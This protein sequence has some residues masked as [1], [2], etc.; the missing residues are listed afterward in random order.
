MN[1][2]FPLDKNL[3]YIKTDKTMKVLSIDIFIYQSV[4]MNG[5]RIQNSIR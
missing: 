3:Y 5:A 2:F 1:L 4:I